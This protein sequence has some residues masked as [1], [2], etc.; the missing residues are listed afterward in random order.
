MAAEFFSGAPDHAVSIV[1]P[2]PLHAAI[3]LDANDV[4]A[5][6]AALDECVAA[7][8]DII[9]KDRT[10]GPRTDG[11]AAAPPMGELAV[12]GA[13]DN[14][15]VAGSPVVALDE[16]G[17]AVDVMR[18]KDTAIVPRAGVLIE[19]PVVE[20]MVNGGINDFEVAVKRCALSCG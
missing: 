11:I 6:V 14:L 18:P 1:A 19:I 5:A 8:R 9:A 17:D 4:Q 16:R 20:T 12:F 13:N 10:L 2:I 3:V 15:E 7:E